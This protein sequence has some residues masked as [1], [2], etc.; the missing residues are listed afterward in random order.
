MKSKS[1]FE[2][3][4]KGLAE[5]QEGKPKTFLIRE[6]L[7]NALDEDI[8]NCELR[9]NQ[10]NGQAVIT[11]T[12]DSPIGFRDLTDAYVLYRTTY[13]RK[14]YNKRGRFNLGEKQVF[15][16]AKKAQIITTT[17]GILFDEKGRHTLKRKREK[18]SEI[19]VWLR[20][21]REEYEQCLD[22][23]HNIYIPEGIEFRITGNDGDAYFPSYQMPYKTFEATLKTEIEQDGV[24]K[25]TSRKTQ[26]H[27]HKISKSSQAY[28]YE[29]G[30][31]ICE[32]ECDY[33]IDVQQK[34]PMS[35][36]RDKVNQSFL[37]ALYAEVLNI[38]YE[39]L[40][41]EDSSNSWVRTATTS[42]R[43]TGEA[44]RDVAIKRFGD[45]AVVF[46]PSDPV[47]N[48]EAIS[49]GYH[50]IRG[51]DMNKDEWAKMR[52]FGATE[53]STS[54]FGKNLAAPEHADPNEEQKLIGEFAK[55]IAKEILNLDI[56]VEYLKNKGAGSLADFEAYGSS[57]RFM[58]RNIPKSNWQVDSNGYINTDMLNLIIHELGHSKG[59]HYEKSYHK[60]LTKLG[61]EL[62]K[63]ALN[64]SKWFKIK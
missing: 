26:V 33:D 17:G 25:P 55:K 23:C 52:E 39:D 10:S 59:Y 28:I 19:T 21:N 49:E 22:Y 12:D 14:E 30:L 43:I 44:V 29:M 9:I 42:D 40:E 51:N 57:L 48:D 2:V 4:K 18:G 34:V 7:Q 13:K 5:L 38:T 24:F 31:P 56:S 27:I 45:K 46:N 61:A 37:K 15:S 20:M 16:I 64:N 47:A 6:L 53:S 32:I 60:C 3:D 36:D 35:A 41:E 63:K 58:I 1:W 54:K 11:V 50:L 8:T 62:T